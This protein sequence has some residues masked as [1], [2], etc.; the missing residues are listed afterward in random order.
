MADEWKEKR[1][2]KRGK[3]VEDRPDE[4]GL[5]EEPDFSDPE[6]FIDDI[7]DEGRLL[8]ML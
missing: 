7:S 8:K 4:N 2:P 1:P 3:S 5:E 6:D